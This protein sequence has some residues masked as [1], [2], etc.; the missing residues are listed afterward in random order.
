MKIE[1]ETLRS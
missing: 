1:S